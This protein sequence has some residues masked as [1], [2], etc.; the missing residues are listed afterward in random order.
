M[1]FAADAPKPATGGEV[2]LLVNGERVAS[3][4]MEHT[5]PARFSGYAGMD[6]GCD[7]GLVVDLSYADKA[8]FRFT[9]EIKQVVFDIA[10]HMSEEDAKALHEHAAQQAT[11]G[12]TRAR[13]R[14]RETFSARTRSRRSS[15][16]D[17]DQLDVLIAVYLIPE[18][19]Q[20]DFEAFVKLAEDK[21]ITTDGVVLVNKDANGEVT[22]Q[23]TGRPPRAQGR[24]GRRRSRPRGRPLRA[25]APRS[26]RGRSCCRGPSSA[27]SPA[28][29]CRRGSARRWTTRCR[30]ARPGSSR[31]TTTTTPKRSP[32]RS[33]TRSARRSRR[34]TRPRQR[35]SKRGSKRRPQGWG[36]EP[37]SSKSRSR[38]RRRHRA[39]PPGSAR[40]LRFISPKR[41]ST[42][43]P[44]CG[45]TR[46]GEALRRA[47]PGRADAA[48]HRCHRR[49]DDR[50]S[51]GDGA[52]AVGRPRPGRPRQ[53]RRHRRAGAHRVP[54]DGRLPTS[55]SR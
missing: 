28:S 26:H 38:L 44:A 15:V 21:T 2:T 49:G 55:S 16:S 42:S 45:E 29:A 39:R 22:V 24:Q 32:A 12:A 30:P 23:E 48:D 41:D 53:Q 14:R 47:G 40:Q 31:S 35:S 19:A 46:T 17:N 33:G 36:A 27:S 37:M 50:G 4:R 25:A 11:R 5:V 13:R 6:I 10:P 54:A 51:C 8:P 34:S 43:S 9:G 52:D 3:G 20:Q 18:L 1:V 7:N